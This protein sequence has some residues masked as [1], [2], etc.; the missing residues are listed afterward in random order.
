MSSSEPNLQNRWSARLVAWVAGLLPTGRSTHPRQK[1]TTIN[2]DRRSS[3]LRKRK[4]SDR[5]FAVGRPG[6]TSRRGS[7]RPRGSPRGGASA[8]RGALDHEG[9]RADIKALESSLHARELNADPGWL[10]SGKRGDDLGH[11]FGVYSTVPFEGRSQRR[12]PSALQAELDTLP[13]T[14]CT[15]AFGCGT[16]ETY[17]IMRGTSGVATLP[18]F[19][20]DRTG[21]RSF[22][23]PRRTLHFGGTCRA[24]IALAD[25]GGSSHARPICSRLTLGTP[26]SLR[27]RVAPTCWTF[28]AAL[29]PLGRN[30]C[31]NPIT[32]VGN[33]AIDALF[34]ISFEGGNRMLMSVVAWARVVLRG[35]VYAY[36]YLAGW[37][38]SGL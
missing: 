32:A 25:A 17:T 1:R 26:Q 36:V 35:R 11:W 13:K 12:D 28:V 10:R 2:R 34:I 14:R 38:G 37:A 21:C 3:P 29:P 5:L 4:G 6:M 20:Q 8:G 31:C 15:H 19:G 16:I 22:A 7:M 18:S 9:A 27:S 23:N 30:V 24:T 33:C